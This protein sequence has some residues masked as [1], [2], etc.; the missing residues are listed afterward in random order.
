MKWIPRDSN[1]QADSLSRIIGCE[2][3]SI[4]EDVV[5]ASGKAVEKFQI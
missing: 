4:N 2:D 5:T 1:N 3:Y